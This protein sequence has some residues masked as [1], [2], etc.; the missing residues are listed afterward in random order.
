MEQRSLLTFIKDLPERSPDK[1]VIGLYVCECGQQKAIIKSRVRRGHTKSCG[2]LSHKNA[3]KT[4]GMHGTKE[5]R[6]W[7]GIKQRCLNTRCKDYYRYGGIGINCHEPW[8][9]SFQ[10]FFDHI[11][12]CP[13]KS[14]S[15][16]RIDN[17]KGYVP[18]NVRWASA[19]TQS[20]N[21]RGTFVWNI[22]GRT[23]ESCVEAAKAHGVSAN[24]VW[25]WVRGSYD[26]RRNTFTQPRGDGN[27]TPRY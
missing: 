24:T 27:A 6:T 26:A 17:N 12:P 7:R 25:R 21:K 18:G 13:D 3:K 4:H 16:D 14:F 8:V 1:H 22:K 5:Y 19:K 2:C 20:K 23:F 11:G 10:S 9:D 15:I